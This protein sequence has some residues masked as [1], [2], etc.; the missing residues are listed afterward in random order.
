[1]LCGRGDLW[2]EYENKP[3]DQLNQSKQGQHPG[4]NSLVEPYSEPYL[5]VAHTVHTKLG[6]GNDS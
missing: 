4:G 2:P 1:M 3:K 5:E 6:Y